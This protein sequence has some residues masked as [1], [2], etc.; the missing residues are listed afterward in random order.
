MILI[1]SDVDSL[2]RVDILMINEEEALQLTGASQLLVAAKGILAMGPK[3]LVLKRG[4]HG[5]LV[6]GPGEHVF[7]TPALL[8]DGVVDPT[9]AGD[10]FAGGFMGYLAG[11]EI[12][13]DNLRRAMGWGTVMASFL[14]QGFSYDRLQGLDR[15]L[16]D[17]RHEELVRLVQYPAG[18]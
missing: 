7:A 4:E 9:G 12:S 5:A 2:E 10:S 17:A 16:I 15:A 3:V 6:F 13:P 8:V 11:R 18:G 14:V 1:H